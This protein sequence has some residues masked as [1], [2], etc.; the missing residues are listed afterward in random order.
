PRQAEADDPDP[1]VAAPRDQRPDGEQT[2]DVGR[3]QYRLLEAGGDVRIEPPRLAVG[4]DRL[5]VESAI[6]TGVHEPREQLRVVAVTLRLAQQ[7]HERG[8]GLTS[9]CL[10]VRVERVRQGKPRVELEGSAE[11]LLGARV[12]VRRAFYELADDAVTATQACPGGSEA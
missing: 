5:F 10:E 7:A 6:A 9:F 2:L 4:G 3:H 8:L 1:L 11:G 12:A